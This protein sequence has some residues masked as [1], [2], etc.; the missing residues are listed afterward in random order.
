MNV[1][2]WA[3]ALGAAVLAGAASAGA[4]SRPLLVPM[5]RELTCLGGTVRLS[6][7]WMLR[8]ETS[9]PADSTSARWLV[10]EARQ[11]FGWTWRFRRGAT[12]SPAVVLRARSAAPGDP[13]LFRVQGYW[14]RVS[15]GGVLIEA[16]TALG[17]FYG[18]QT[19]RQLLRGARDR[20]LPVLAIR[21]FPA[22]E[23]RGVSDDIS[24][25]QISTLDDF[26]SIVR[27]LAYYKL[28]LYQPYIEDMFAFAASPAAGRSRGALTPVEL[29]A[30]VEEGRRNHVLVVPIL[31]SLA[32]QER[33]LALPE[34]QL[35]ADRPVTKPSTR[36]PRPLQ[37]LLAGWLGRDARDEGDPPPPPPSRFAANRPEALAFVTRLVDEVAS[38]APGPFFHVG[39]DEAMAGD[40]PATVGE[41]GPEV[42]DDAWGRW[43]GALARHLRRRGRRMMIYGDVLLARPCV[44]ARIPRDAV[45]VDWCYDPDDSLTSVRRLRAAG[46][47]DVFVSPGLWNWTAFYP[48]YNRAFRNIRTATAAGKREGATGCVAAS[49]GDNGAEN[50]R[51]NNWTGY[52][53]AAAATWEEQ[54]PGDTEFLRRF[55]AVRHGVDSPA[56]AQVEHLLGWQPFAGFTYNAK[57]YHRPPRVRRHYPVWTGRMSALRHD[58]LEARRLVER[59]RPLVRWERD[60]L[61]E[62]DLAARRFEYSAERE[63]ALDRIARTLGGRDA[64]ALPDSTRARCVA[65]LERLRWQSAELTAEVGRL[66][67]RR[68]RVPMLQDNLLRMRRQSEALEDLIRQMQAGSLRE[69]PWAPHLAQPR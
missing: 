52:A 10:E 67:C 16:P 27:R 1:K 7:D 65:D 15:G 40:D 63:L 61:D 31:E 17:R 50:L 35:Y 51:E 62:L 43:F 55:V 49:W 13:P 39:G 2:S 68:N 8:I 48:A 14:L 21:D 20:R 33:L 29:T 69:E 30:L 36:W 64:R 32:H 46:F 11:C 5:P 57:L 41:T 45:V 66:W 28:N 38:A 59:S 12:S 9:E 47:R 26:R 56:L 24:R 4:G 25:G 58:A 18:A 54:A 23:W 53:F 34:N 19:L 6:R 44:L 22:L 37:V 60:H 42:R 3:L